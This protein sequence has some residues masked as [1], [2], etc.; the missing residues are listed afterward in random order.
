MTTAQGSGRD[1]LTELDQ[2][3]TAEEI[4]D[5]WRAAQDA[6]ELTVVEVHAFARD[7][8]T[9][10]LKGH[11]ADVDADDLLG[12]LRQERREIACAATDV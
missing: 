4:R 3:G 9:R 2:C 8:R 1:W 12:A 11:G 10:P 6:G 7:A 5:L